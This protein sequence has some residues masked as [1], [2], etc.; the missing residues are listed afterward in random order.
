MTERLDQLRKLYDADPTDPFVTYGMALE[1]AKVH[2]PNQA[3]AWFDK[4]L[5]LDPHYCYAYYHKA[6][7][8]SEQGD[9]DSARTVLAKGMAAAASAGDDHARSEMAELLESLTSG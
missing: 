9:D 1:H 7:I 4:T 2:K 8:L 6:R 5:D 3:L